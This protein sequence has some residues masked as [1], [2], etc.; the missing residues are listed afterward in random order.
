MISWAD[1]V[2]I[3]R[4]KADWRCMRDRCG[5]IWVVYELERAGAESDGTTA[6]ESRPVPHPAIDRLLCFESPRL[7]KCLATYPT[8]WR[9]RSDAELQRL[10]RSA[11][12]LI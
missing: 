12:R 7:R 4:R 11:R 3:G 5:E 8:D 2:T 9:A 6:S 1:S 10:L